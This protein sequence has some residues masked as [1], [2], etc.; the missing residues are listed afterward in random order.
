MNKGLKMAE[1]VITL[2]NK[3]YCNSQKTWFLILE[4]INKLVFSLSH[5]PPWISVFSS[6]K[7]GN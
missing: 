7:Y 4:V 2:I 5:L 3:K 6:V 1:L